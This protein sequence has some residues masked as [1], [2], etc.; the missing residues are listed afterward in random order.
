M[1]LSTWLR[2]YLYIPLGGNKGSRFFTYRNLMITMVLGGIWH[3][4]AMHFAVWGFYQGILLVVHKEFKHWTDKVA[5]FVR[6]KQSQLFHLFSIILTFHA[7]CLGWVFFRAENLSS[8]MLIINVCCSFLS[9]QIYKCKLPQSFCADNSKCERISC[10]FAFAIMLAAI[11]LVARTNLGCL[12]NELTQFLYCIKRW[13]AAAALA[14]SICLLVIFSP[15]YA[16][17]F[18]YFQ[19]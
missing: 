12:I 7:V 8:A 2:D 1:S 5:W 11:T 19:F 15:D 18:I 10:I 3:G 9:C 14:I 16:P 6:L 17:Q 13:I 4:A